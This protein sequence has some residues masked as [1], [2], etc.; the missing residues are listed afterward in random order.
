VNRFEDSGEET[1]CQLR[2]FFHSLGAMT[3]SQDRHR[4]RAA[5]NG[6]KSVDCEATPEA[7]LKSGA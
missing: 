6:A 7:R 3:I 1:L 4:H 2:P 5:G